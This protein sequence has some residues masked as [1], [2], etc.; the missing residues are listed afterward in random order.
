VIFW[1]ILPQTSEKQLQNFGGNAILIAYNKTHKM[2]FGN[3]Q[4][5]THGVCG[6]VRAVANTKNWRNGKE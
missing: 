4:R 5:P 3:I 2:P 1:R 6:T